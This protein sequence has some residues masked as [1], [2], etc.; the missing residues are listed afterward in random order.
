MYLDLVDYSVCKP[1]SINSLSVSSFKQK[2]FIKKPISVWKEIYSILNN[3][4]QFFWK[5]SML[6]DVGKY[7]SLVGQHEFLDGLTEEL[8]GF[9][10]KK[11][12]RM[13]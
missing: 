9:C 12:E 7:K 11:S 3:L 13:T 6:G 10:I 2:S 5:L 4:N 1:Q 8:P